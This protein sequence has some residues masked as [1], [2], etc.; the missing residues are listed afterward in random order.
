[1][2]DDPRDLAAELAR[3]G[4]P[5]GALQVADYQAAVVACA[6]AA[7][8]LRGF[9]LPKLLEQID[10]ADALGPILDPTLWRDRSPLMQEDRA[11]LHAA[12]GLWKFGELLD[13]HA[14]APGGEGGR[15]PARERVRPDRQRVP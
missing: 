13:E 11:L 7:R 14:R 15:G 1:M 2:S 9:D 5:E 4:D 12:L 8:M 10:R 6:V 3:A